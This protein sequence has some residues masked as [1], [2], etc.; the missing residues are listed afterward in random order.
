MLG[1]DRSLQVF[2]RSPVREGSKKTVENGCTWEWSVL[3]YR[4]TLYAYM[5]D[6]M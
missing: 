2:E 3:Y 6:G 1:S 4:G 5:K